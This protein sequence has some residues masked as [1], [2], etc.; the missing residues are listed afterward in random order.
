MVANRSYQTDM[1]LVRNVE[2]AEVEACT[3]F[4]VTLRRPTPAVVIIYVTGE[5]DMLTELSLQSSLKTVFATDPQRLII[6]LSEVSFLGATGLS[7]LIRARQA[8]AEQGATLQL[9]IPNRR[10]VTRLLT[11]TGLDRLFDILPSSNAWDSADPARSS[12]RLDI[13]RRD[14]MQCRD[15]GH[16]HRAMCSIEAE[17]DED[18]YAHLV[19]LQRRHAALAAGH[20][21]RRKLRDQLI[22]GYLPVARNIARRFIGR[23]EPLEDL[24]QIATVGLINAVD[25]FDPTRGSHFLAFAVP[26]ITGEIRRY[27]RDHGWSTRVP[28]QLKDLHVSIRRAQADLSQRLGRAPHVSEIAEHLD[29]S[30]SRIIDGLVAGEA[31]GTSSLDEA[32]GCED[33]ATTRGEMIGTTND[34]FALIDD[35]ETVRPVLARLTPRQQTILMLRF[36]HHWTQDRIAA[37]LGVSQMQISRVLCQTLQF[38][39]HHTT[40][41]D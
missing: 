18:E 40:I 34:E 36:F 24:T 19:P 31:W 37:N 20:P 14:E 32:V 39:R 11:T 12:K 10:L 5:I 17:G 4:S 8:A 13:P 30:T 25:R 41:V 23:G 38:L 28:R 26:T 7:F 29:L 16:P 1:P 22:N 33:G 21:Q 6:D 27:F 35:R 9:T 2:H 3:A 15:G